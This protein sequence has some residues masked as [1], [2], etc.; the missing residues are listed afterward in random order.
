MIPRK[1]LVTVFILVICLTA[2]TVPASAELFGDL[3]VGP[4][5][6]QDDDLTLKG[7][8]AGTVGIKPIRFDNAVSFGGRI[9]YWLESVPYVGFDLDVSHFRPD[10]K[11]GSVTACVPIFFPSCAPATVLSTDLQVTGISFDAMF[12]LPLLTSKEFPKGQLQPYLTV[13]PTVFVTH[14]ED[15]GNF[16]R[17]GLQFKQ[18]DTNTTVG[19]KAG[20]GLAW[21]FH[22]NIALFGEYRFTHVSPS[23][24]LHDDFFGKFDEKTTLNTHRV[25]FGVSFRLPTP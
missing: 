7:T 20:A 22:R 1:P 19:V 13:G 23:F 16:T 2:V 8:A 15:S 11:K 12:R 18:D 9:G 10:I 17:N 24:S 25:V 6:T 21:Q 3:F 5:F 14:A 4:A